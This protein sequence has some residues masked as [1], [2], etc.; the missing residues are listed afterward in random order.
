MSLK[1]ANVIY[2]LFLEHIMGHFI[3][4]SVL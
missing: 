4:K 1:E 3:F 2:K